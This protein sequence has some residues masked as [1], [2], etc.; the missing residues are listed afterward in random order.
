MSRP[1]VYSKQKARILV[2][3]NFNN[4]NILVCYVYCMALEES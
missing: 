1:L 3:N 4:N 2:N